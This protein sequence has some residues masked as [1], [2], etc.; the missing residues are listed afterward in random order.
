MEKLNWSKETNSLALEQQLEEE[1]LTKNWDWILKKVSW[2]WDYTLDIEN[3]IQTRII[4]QL[5]AEFKLMN[6]LKVTK[7]PKSTY[8]YWVKKMK[9]ENPDREIGKL[10]LTIFKENDEN[11]GYRWITLV[12]HN[13]GIKINY[14]KVFIVP[15]KNLD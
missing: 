8:D 14:K 1:N 13:Q 9:Q 3:Q 12:L 6:I 10:I 2:S 11:C 15:W 7:F 4:Q 5:T